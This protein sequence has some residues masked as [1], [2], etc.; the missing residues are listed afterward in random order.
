M[1]CQSNTQMLFESDSV[2]L[3]HNV[4]SIADGGTTATK[5]N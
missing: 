4:Q 1:G 5:T 2:V 3:V